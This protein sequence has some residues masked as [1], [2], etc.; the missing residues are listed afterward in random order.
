MAS[1]CAKLVVAGVARQRYEATAR[2]VWV[3]TDQAELAR[4]AIAD[5][6]V[7]VRRLAVGQLVDVKL[8]KKVYAEATDVEV[9]VIVVW[10][11]LG[12]V[13]LEDD[14][15]A[16][17]RVAVKASQA[18]KEQTFDLGNGV[19]MEFVWC[20][21]GE[22][23]MGSPVGESG[24]DSDEVQHRV[25]LTKGFW[26]GKYEVTQEQWQQV[27]GGNP[28]K[29]RDAG[30]RAPVEQVSWD[31]CQG[32]AAKLN[33]RANG[34]SAAW[35]REFRLPTEAAVGPRGIRAS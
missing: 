5:T 17:L 11:L 31:D 9:R 12:V 20:P 25:T 32:F 34:S 4:L 10:K 27:M 21:P 15:P 24:R 33:A 3:V 35:G 13:P 18:V 8:L 2:A 7:E 30:L 19:T 22:F 23:I 16:A 14:D 29:F 6:D 28:P 1:W 26:L